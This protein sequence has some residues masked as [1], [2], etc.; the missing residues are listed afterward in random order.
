[1]FTTPA[2][3][4]DHAPD[5]PATAPDAAP[6]RRPRSRGQSLAE[7]ALTVPFAL[8]MVLFGLDFGRVFLGWVALSNAAREASNYAAMNP[9]AWTL[10][11][12]LAV[13]AE[14]TR[15]VQTEASSINC[16][17]ES[18]IPPPTFPSGTSI[19]APA[20]AKLTC[21]FGLI[22]PFISL[23]LGN[24][25]PVSSSS[26]FPVRSGT[27][28]GIPVETLV[29]SP[30]AGS[31]ASAAPT[32]SATPTASPG[33]SSSVN[34]SASPTATPAPTPTATPATCTVVSLL[35]IQTNKAAAKWIDAGFSGSVI[36]TPLVP[37]NYKILWQSLTVGTTQSCS[38]G[39]N[40]RS[41]AP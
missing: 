14:Y 2:T 17:L 32:A 18:P 8:F 15:L 11:Y 19:G 13:Q 38:S 29:P 34:P 1:M 4:I 21:Q 31:T 41:R 6:K 36:F 16:I 22:T 12:N 9:T 23:I 26:A 35:N 25:I 28:E 5:A 33:P 37:P 7:F 30:T 3:P 20:N 40:V 10:P 27:I 39:I 24:T